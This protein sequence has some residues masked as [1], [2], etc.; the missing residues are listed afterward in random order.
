MKKTI[1][2]GSLDVGMVANAASPH[3]YKEVFRQD[4]IRQSQEES[5]DTEIFHQMAFIMAMQAE[6]TAKEILELN[7]L[8]YIEWLEQF[9]PMDLMDAVP[10]IVGFYAEQEKRTSRPKAKGV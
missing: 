4:F 9:A 10:A 3:Y 6:K 1:K 5:V 2:I 7:E 8:D